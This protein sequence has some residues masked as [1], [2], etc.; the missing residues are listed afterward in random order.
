[1][2]DRAQRDRLEALQLERRALEEE[3]TLTASREFTQ[4]QQSLLKRAHQLDA[5]AAPLADQEQVVNAELARLREENVRLRA[6]L[7]HGE[8]QSLSGELVVLAPVFVAGLAWAFNQG[9][10]PLALV[11]AGAFIVGLLLGTR[12]GSTDS[13]GSWAMGQVVPSLGAAIAV[14]GALF[15][16]AAW[17]THGVSFDVLLSFRNSELVEHLTWTHVVQLAVLLT[18]LSSTKDSGRL[19][20]ALAAVGAVVIAASWYQ[21]VPP[22]HAKLDTWFGDQRVPVQEEP[23]VLLGQN[24]DDGVAWRDPIAARLAIIPTA[25]LLSLV[26]LLAFFGRRDQGRRHWLA[27]PLLVLTVGLLAFVVLLSANPNTELPLA[28]IEGFGAQALIGLGVLQWVWVNAPAA[29]RWRRVV[30]LFPMGLVALVVMKV[31]ISG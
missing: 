15:V 13:V 4:K 6:E 9:M 7:R 10:P 11:G 28:I 23:W 24:D 27:I 1:M 29:S 14:I 16:G 5:D 22:T 26:A 20:L 18:V 31:L 21:W 8:E 3:L 30:L 2:S 17:G 25:G 19:P 12:L